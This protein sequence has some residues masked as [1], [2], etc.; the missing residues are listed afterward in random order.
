MNNKFYPIDLERIKTYEFAIL[1]CKFFQENNL[2]SR[3]TIFLEKVFRSMMGVPP[4]SAGRMQWWTFQRLFHRARSWLASPKRIPPVF[5]QGR[6][7]PKMT[8]TPTDVKMIGKCGYSIS[9]EGG[10]FLKHNEI[11]AIM[12][13]MIDKGIF[14]NQK[15]AKELKEQ[16]SLSSFLHTKWF[17]NK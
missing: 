7:I 15:K 17:D 11:L 6:K 3:R 1:I 14:N 16:K 2:Y 8:S 5:I 13:D 4:K 9:K 10:D 12:R